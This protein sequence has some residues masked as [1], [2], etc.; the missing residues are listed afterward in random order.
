MALFPFEKA[1]IFRHFLGKKG[2]ARRKLIFGFAPE[3]LGEKRQG[4]RRRGG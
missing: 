3:H 2:D 4:I 1:A